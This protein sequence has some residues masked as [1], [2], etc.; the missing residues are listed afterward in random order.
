[1]G[2]CCSKEPLYEVVSEDRDEKQYV[3]DGEDDDENI[4]DDGAIVRLQGPSA[5]TSMFTKQGK[6]GIN[7]DAMTVWEV[8][9]IINFFF[10]TILSILLSHA[11]E[12]IIGFNWGYG[13]I[14]CSFEYLSSSIM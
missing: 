8:P 2:T 14:I 3:R 12:P 11:N 6:K 1:M 13:Y 7:Q 4:A 10:Y 5:F 9:V